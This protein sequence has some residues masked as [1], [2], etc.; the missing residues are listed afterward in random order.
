MGG[1]CTS[2]RGQ[3]GRRGGGRG[4]ISGHQRPSAAVSGD[5]R[6]SAA[7]S[8]DQ[9]CVSPP[10]PAD[11]RSPFDVLKTRMMN[12]HT[13]NQLYTN[14]FECATS[15]VRVEGVTAL[16][17]GLLP[18]YVRQVVAHHLTGCLGFAHH[19][20]ALWTKAWTPLPYVERI[21][22]LGRLEPHI[23][24]NHALTAA[25]P[26]HTTT[27]SLQYAELHDTRTA[28]QS[29]PRQVSHVIA[30]FALLKQTLWLRC[31]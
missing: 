8:G 21:G 31:W 29:S 26:H 6:R 27:G 25:C 23:H 18:V 10:T 9:R 5:Q 20:N 19:T 4:A 24:T 2:I 22:R 13:T 30:M 14:V 28:H 7:I 15:V 17:K 1:Q 3:G 16:W 11:V 12:Q